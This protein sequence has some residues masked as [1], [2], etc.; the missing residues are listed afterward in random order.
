MCPSS[1]YEIN[2]WTQISFSASIQLDLFSRCTH[3]VYNIKQW[4]QGKSVW[5]KRY[6]FKK[7]EFTLK[8][9]HAQLK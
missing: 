1:N 8:R 5:L 3:Q 7:K 2:E 6:D 4:I 9:M